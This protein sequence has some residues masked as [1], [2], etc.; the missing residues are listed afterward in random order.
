MNKKNTTL[1]HKELQTVVQEWIDHVILGEPPELSSLRSE[2][3]DHHIARCCRIL[4]LIPNPV[5]R[6]RVLELGSGLYLMTFIV[7]RL[8]NYDL[9][10]VQYW[11]KQNGNYESLLVSQ[12]TG[13]EIVLPFTQFNAEVDRFPYPDNTFDVLLNC[14][15]IEHLLCNPVHMLAECHRVLKPKGLI[16]VSTPNVLRLTNLIRL[17]QGKNIYDKYCQESPYGRHPREYSPEEIFRLFNEVGYSVKLLETRDILPSNNSAWINFIARF[18]ISIAGLIS[19]LRGG[20]NAYRSVK[21]RGE[22]IFLSAEKS[23]FANRGLPV[24]LYEAPDFQKPLIDAICRPKT[25]IKE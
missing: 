3:V 9:E 13:K 19:K 15:I 1:E 20:G 6:G 24:F 12:K 21:W 4:N 2:Y 22:Q 14:D 17:I 8:R 11:G 23:G 5:K 25:R 16:I 7:M 18:I 10:L